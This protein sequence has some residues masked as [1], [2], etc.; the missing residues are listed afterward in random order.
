MKRIVLGL[1]LVTA[2]VTSFAQSK[3]KKNVDVMTDKVTYLVDN[4]LIMANE[5]ETKGFSIDPYIVKTD[6]TLDIKSFIVQMAGLGACNED[7]NII[8]LFENEEKIVVNSWNDF[9]CK[10]VAYFDVT[11]SMKAKLSK[12][13][14]SKIRVTNGRTHNYYTGTPQK[15]YMVTLYKTLKETSL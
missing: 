11:D 6:S 15:D 1:T 8:I 5:A 13:N 3:I 12:Y 10:G 2:T 4:A 7:N 9:N 14:I